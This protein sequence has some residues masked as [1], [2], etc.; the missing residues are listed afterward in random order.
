MD[1]ITETFAEFINKYNRQ[2]TKNQP[3]NERISLRIIQELAPEL[4]FT[5][6][7]L[8]Q[9]FETKDTEGIRR[10]ITRMEQL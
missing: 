10:I 4:E 3:N 7:R 6:E 8:T 5:N 9:L 1:R 2:K